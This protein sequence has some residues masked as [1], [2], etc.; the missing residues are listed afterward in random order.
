MVN[1]KYAMAAV[2]TVNLFFIVLS[3]IDYMDMQRMLR[4]TNDLASFSTGA[5]DL[6][7]AMAMIQLE[8]NNPE[9]CTIVDSAYYQKIG[10]TNALM[11]K[12]LGYERANLFTEFFAL[13]RQFLLSNIQLWQVSQMER[14][15]CYANHSDLHLL[16]IYSSKPS[17]SECQIQGRMID[18]VRESCKNVRVFVMDIEESMTSLDIIKKKYGITSAPSLVIDGKTYK[19]VMDEAAIKKAVSCGS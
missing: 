16:Y 12:M 6:E 13:K 11:E 10:Q 4:F 9:Y 7:S 15:Y 1:L 3:V 17:C 5:Q 8:K 14:Q 19:G 2:L 18:S